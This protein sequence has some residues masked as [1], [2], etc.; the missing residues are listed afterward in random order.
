MIVCGVLCIA[1]VAQK[2]EAKKVIA[3]QLPRER[4]Y[5]P[6]FRGKPEE[7]IE[8]LEHRLSDAIRTKDAEV[9]NELLA[10]K[11]LIFG[12]RGTKQQY[13]I[14]LRQ[15]DTKFTSIEKSEMRIQIDGDT[16]V[17]TGVINVDISLENG[18]TSSQA[19]FLNVWKR[20]DGAWRCIA[21][22]N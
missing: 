13:A 10:D 15:L 4:V 9:L 21:L 2:P 5:N 18:G 11:V 7:Q 17:A 16:A 12:M 6:E 8:L 22:V 19:S 14:L 1:A 20:I 3:N